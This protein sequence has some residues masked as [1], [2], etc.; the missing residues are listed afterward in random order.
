MENRTTL[1]KLAKNQAARIIG[2]STPN[3][4][5][6][7]RFREIGFAEGDLVKILHIGLFGRSPVNVKLHG[8]SIAMRPAQAA[9]I[10]VE[11]VELPLIGT[12]S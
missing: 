11:I 12:G 9:M 1:A 4:H 10:N 3:D 2:F 5:L 7:T 6:E 8:T